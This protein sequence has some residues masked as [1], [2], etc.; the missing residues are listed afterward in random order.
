MHTIETS[1]AP[2]PDLADALRVAPSHQPQAALTVNDDAVF[3]PGAM[4]A[5]GINAAL[6]TE[7]A[8]AVVGR[9]AAAH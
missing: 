4:T 9:P 6:A 3:R 1:G 2:A 5:A 8:D 7:D